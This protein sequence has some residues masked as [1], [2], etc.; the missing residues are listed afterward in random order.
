[1]GLLHTKCT[2]GA[3][4]LTNVSFKTKLDRVYQD[5]L[6]NLNLTFVV[7]DV[8]WPVIVPLS[9][10]ITVPYVVCMGV[11][12]GLGELSVRLV[13]VCMGRISLIASS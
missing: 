5:G 2:C 12:P 6:R 10:F 8:A 3:I 4:W 7:R 9:L 1:M 11:L 13:H